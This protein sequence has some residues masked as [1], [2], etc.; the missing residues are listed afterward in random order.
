M[1]VAANQAMS[2]DDG[3][4]SHHD[5]H[6]YC[7]AYPDD[8]AIRGFLTDVLSDDSIVV[9]PGARG[10]F[11]WLAWNTMYADRP[12]RGQVLARLHNQKAL[13][14]ELGIGRATVQRA[15]WELASQQ[16][17]TYDPA[18]N[19]GY[20]GRPKV[21][22]MG[23]WYDKLVRDWRAFHGSEVDDNPG[24]QDDAT[25]GA[26]MMPSTTKNELG[27]ATHHEG[28]LG[29]PSGKGTSPET[30]SPAQPATESV[31]PE[32]LAAEVAEAFSNLEEPVDVRLLAKRVSDLPSSTNDIREAILW[33]N[34]FSQGPYNQGCRTFA[35]PG[36]CRQ[37]GRY[38]YQVL[39]DMVGAWQRSSWDKARQL[40]V[41]PQGFDLNEWLKE[42]RSEWSEAS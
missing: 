12:D 25:L 30:A 1:S 42:H 41:D 36:Y 16:L 6:E 39:P 3:A 24:H 32:S 27:E 18:P 17:I 40:G 7:P 35:E 31:T 38:I 9:N 21:I 29:T 33:W 4:L 37:P 11:I 19:D 23:P 34:N 5:C 28:E 20:H 14:A 13:A 8:R 2:N 15:L 26:N 22:A 10:V